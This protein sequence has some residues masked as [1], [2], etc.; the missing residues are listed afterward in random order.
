MV[1]A[2][3]VKN[4]VPFSEFFFSVDIHLSDNVEFPQSLA[5]LCGSDFDT[6]VKWVALHTWPGAIPSR[7][8]PGDRLH[9]VLPDVLGLDRQAL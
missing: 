3:L 4:G 8:I 1:C 5:K 7:G 6:S 9:F 2:F